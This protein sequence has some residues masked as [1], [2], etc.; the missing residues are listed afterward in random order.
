MKKDEKALTEIKENKEIVKQPRK[1]TPK[2]PK[3][4]LPRIFKKK[5]TK[6]N[7]NKKLLKKIFIEDD[8]KYI[9]SIFTETK[10]VNKKNKEKITFAI[11]DDKLFTQIEAK[12]L[13]SLSKE[14]K[15]QKGTIKF[16]PL[17]IFIG[18]VISVFIFTDLILTMGLKST[19]QGIFK[20]KVDIGYAHL[21]Y[22]KS[23]I[24]IKNFA[25]ANKD[26]PMNNLFQ[27]DSIVFDIDINRMLNKQFVID[28]IEAAGFAVGTPRKTSGEIKQKKE[29]STPK[30]PLIKPEQI[31]AIKTKL[32]TELQKIFAKFDPQSI[33]DSTYNKLQTPVS[34]EKIIAEL[35]TLIPYWKEKPEEFSNQ[36][37]SFMAD[38]K[39]LESI[40]FSNITDLKQIE[41]NI[42]LIT[43]TISNG[44]KISNNFQGTYN[45]LQ[46]D[47]NNV[48]KLTNNLEKAIKNDTQLAASITANIKSFTPEAGGKLVANILEDFLNGLL[49]DAYPKAKELLALIQDIKEKLPEKEKTETE[50]QPKPE[51]L[52]GI[53]FY[54]GQPELPK[55]LVR[56]AHASGSGFDFTANNISSNPTLINAPMTVEGTYTIQNRQDSFNITLDLRDNR[57]SSMLT[58][59]Y[60]A[61]DVLTQFD[62]LSSTATYDIQFS[63]EEDASMS[64]Y[65]NANLIETDF[66]L[67][68]FEPAFAYDICNKSI[69]QI[70]TTYLS[71]MANLG[72]KEN[73]KLNL[74]T[75]FDNKFMK[76]VTNHVNKEL[77][78]LK[79]EATKAISIKLDEYSAPVKEKIAEFNVYKTKIEDS[80]KQLDKKLAE[81]KSQLNKE[82]EKLI[83]LG[84]AKAQDAVQDTVNKYVDTSK[85]DSIKSW[86]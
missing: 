60:H 37:N 56:K 61:P 9:K 1:K 69:E 30:E 75:D 31:E 12:R 27:F 72:G 23:S 62:F 14:I 49:G 50:E 39:K 66:D 68:T 85:L 20:A 53:N 84:K 10:T 2:I 52:D 28:E 58:A 46:A 67:P 5:Y 86:F 25:V 71:V 42:A 55:F 21:D 11:Q 83:N 44:E 45:K 19:F 36:L 6:K 47:F 65:G 82:R 74:N 81:L 17:F 13:K 26:A 59:N 64:I 4:K 48:N 29:E 54:W 7:F 15:K 34:S 24:S 80:K 8:K 40:N 63:A 78:A 51:R 22:L 77:T 41:E 32:S 33:L 18:I 76:S 3:K 16:I 35:N 43:N 73:L 38:V 70:D 79:D 57:T